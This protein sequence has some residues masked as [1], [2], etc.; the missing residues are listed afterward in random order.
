MDMELQ[1]NREQNGLIQREWDELAFD[2]K[3]L[4]RIEDNELLLAENGQVKGR[5][6]ATLTEENC[7]ETFEELTRKFKEAQLQFSHIQDEWQKQED[8]TRVSATVKRFHNFFSKLN[9]LGNFSLILKPLKAME[10]ELKSVLATNYDVRLAI[11]RKAEAMKDASEIKAEDWNSLLEEWKHAPFIEKEENDLL[12]MKFDTARNSFYEKK[13][14]LIEDHNRELMQNLDWKMEVCEQA[15]SWANSENWKEGTEAFKVLFERWKD[16]GHVPSIEKNDALW[17]RFRAAKDA[18]FNRKAAHFEKIKVEQEENY[19]L[20]L[21]LVAEAE[22][23][24]DATTWKATSEHFSQLMNHW[25]SIGK[26][27]FEKA[28]E[29]WQRLQAARDCFYN[30]RRQS[31]NEIK[32]RLDENLSIKEGLADRAQKIK[33]STDWE[34]ATKEMNQLMADWKKAG[35]VPKEHSDEVWGR[36]LASRKHFFARK[37]A[38]REKR[39]AIFFKK[40]NGRLEQTRQF[41]AKLRSEHEED[42][43][44]LDDFQQSL[45]NTTGTTARDHELRTHL[46]GLIDNLKKRMPSREEK[47]NEVEK[48]LESLK[49][50]L[51]QSEQHHADESR[52]QGIEKEISGQEND[53]PPQENKEERQ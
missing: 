32:E 50:T 44:N 41:L 26:V 19:Q 10:E 7:R 21:K 11:V 24:K 16:I 23:I 36:F 43:L 40:L 14:E 52:A 25:K 46:S 8:K 39:K 13:Q 29:L 27:P 33:D 1:Q 17:D 47:I 30:A 22:G 4:F 51:H 45:K 5:V 53:P 2:G 37:D 18:F 28:E 48:Q 9:G 6:V 31:M 42:Q 20:K 49:Q 12:W 35:A 3:Y 15:E 34:D 38:D